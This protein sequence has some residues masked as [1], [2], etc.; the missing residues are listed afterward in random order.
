MEILT[1][2]HLFQRSTLHPLPREF[3]SRDP[4][5]V[6]RELLGHFLVHETAQVRCVGRIVEVEAYGGEDDPASHARVRTPRS[7][8]MWGAPGIAYVYFIYGNHHCL[9]VVTEPEGIPGAVLIRALEPLEGIE[10]MQRRRG[11][12]KLT[13]LA[14][15]PGRLT[16][17]MGIN[18]SHNG[19]DLTRP[20]LYIADG[21]PTPFEV[22]A[23]PRIGVIAAKERLW[24]FYIRGSPFVSRR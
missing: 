19:W 21:S 6:A 16:Q 1:S 15:G 22:E 10:W 18:L 7:E 4:V 11:V 17:A 12:E 14:S 3:F 8:I 23:T 9:N 2:A 24:R 20:P 5:S 13:L